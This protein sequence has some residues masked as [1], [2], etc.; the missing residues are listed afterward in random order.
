[1]FLHF[2][3]PH[4]LN[5]LPDLLLLLLKLLIA[6]QVDSYVV[7]LLTYFLFL[8]RT[9]WEKK[10]QSFFNVLLSIFQVSW[11]LSALHRF[12]FLVQLIQDILLYF[13]GFS[14]ILFFWINLWTDTNILF[15]GSF[16]TITLNRSNSLILLYV[17][18]L[19]RRLLWH[20]SWTFAPR[21][22]TMR[23]FSFL[24]VYLQFPFFFLKILQP[25]FMQQCFI[26]FFPGFFQIEIIFLFI[27][28]ILILALGKGIHFPTF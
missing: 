7:R 24:W 10:F 20:W 8:N 25:V 6:I 15:N 21:S 5:F 12:I 23:P 16:D 18:Y 1:L 19:Q 28:L 17:Y 14:S 22:A 9:I 13:L 26:Q 3:I 4:F 2:N 27:L 11:K